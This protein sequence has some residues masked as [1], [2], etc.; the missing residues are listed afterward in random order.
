MPWSVSLACNAEPHLAD[1]ADELRLVQSELANEWRDTSAELV[2][3]QMRRLDRR[4]LDEIR[5]STTR[6]GREL[7]VLGWL[8]Q[9]VGEP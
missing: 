6:S 1:E 5:Q 3:A 9:D 2:P 4:S 7:G 8:H